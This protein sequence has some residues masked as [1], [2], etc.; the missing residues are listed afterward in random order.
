MSVKNLNAHLPEE[1]PVEFN[2]SAD[3]LAG[4]RFVKN[5]MPG[6]NLFKDVFFH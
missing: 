6:W 4:H 3:F 2:A 1:M 5:H